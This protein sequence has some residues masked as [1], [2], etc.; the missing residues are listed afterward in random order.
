MGI[1]RISRLSAATGAAIALTAAGGAKAG[2]FICVPPQAGV[3]VVSGGPNGTCDSVSTPVQLPTA[4][5]DQKKLLGMLPYMDFNAT[6]V[7]AKPT[8][9]IQGANLQLRRTSQYTTDGT[10][11]L[12][13]GNSGND[14]VAAGHEGVENLIMGHDDKWGGSGNFIMGVFNSVPASSNVVIGD[15]HSVSG[16]ENMVVGGSSNTVTGRRNALLGQSYATTP[17]TKQILADGKPISQVHWAKFDGTGKLLASSEPVE[18]YGSSYYGLVKFPNVD[19][20][21]CA[22]SAQNRQA[23][24]EFAATVATDYYGYIYARAAQVTDAGAVQ[25]GGVAMDVTAACDK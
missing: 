16:I 1:S 5:A 21:K 12:Q 11:N 20:A 23:N 9:V 25:K 14:N 4:A 15:N 17:G 22:V 2:T 18:F 19:P 24:G 10:G 3:A 13:I 7:G 6:G 8:I